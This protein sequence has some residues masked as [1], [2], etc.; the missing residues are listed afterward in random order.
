VRALERI[1]EADLS[2]EQ[3]A[4]VKQ[5]LVTAARRMERADGERLS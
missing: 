4:A 3:L 5:W 2:P 1:A